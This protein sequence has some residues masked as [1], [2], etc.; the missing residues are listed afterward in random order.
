MK[1]STGARLILLVTALTCGAQA[2]HA[3]TGC[4]LNNPQEDLAV[5]FDSFTDFTIR[6]T[7]FAN[8]SPEKFPTLEERMGAGLD[9]V[10]ETIDVPYTLYTV[11][12]AGQPM[13]YV[14]GANQRGKYSN[15]QII[16]G[17]DIQGNL[18][19]VHLQKIRSPRSADFLS[20]DFLDA[21]AET[22]FETFPRWDVCFQGGQCNGVTVK[23]P[24]GGAETED[25]KAI[26]RGLAKLFH[27]RDLL[28]NPGQNTRPDGGAAR[29]EHLS[30]HWMPEQGFRPLIKPPKKSLSSAQGLIQDEAEPVAVVMGRT[31]TFIYPISLLTLHPVIED[32][33][34]EK[35]G[36]TVTWS[37]PTFTLS[38]LRI[39]DNAPWR[40]S[41]SNS[42]VFGHQTLIDRQAR[43]DWSAL[44]G[45]P[46][47]SPLNNSKLDYHTAA[48]TMPWSMAK[49]FFPDASVA[50]TQDSYSK[51]QAFYEAH[52]SRF[53]VPNADSRVW[54][55]ESASST[56][57]IPKGALKGEGLYILSDEK[58][59]LVMFTLDDWIAAYEV[60]EGIPADSLEWMGNDIPRGV[61][62]LASEAHGVTWQATTGFPVSGNLAAGKLSP[63]LIREMS[64]KTAEAF[65]PKGASGITWLVP[66]PLA[67][68]GEFEPLPPR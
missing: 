59:T 45:L 60:P 29:A 30:L 56:M 7:T 28:L 20:S 2:A 34:D 12:A 14:F 46:V 42:V 32:T 68:P 50:Y 64:S 53:H 36:L 22:P 49:R 15:I 54:V 58:E 47:D 4:S 39:T 41:N 13:G 38:V 61:P 6:Y 62:L 31:E 24:T 43:K 21:L 48:W 17:T 33:I 52:A 65:F 44:S 57:V 40:F 25:Y 5:F 11:Y 3:A 1:V 55:A 18:Q 9:P 63:V 10:Y 67:S 35:E 37:S 27:I 23:D 8:Q 26:L 19:R 16:A 51:H 66:R